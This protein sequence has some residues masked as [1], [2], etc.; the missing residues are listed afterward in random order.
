MFLSAALAV[1]SAR[2]TVVPLVDAVAF[3]STAAAESRPR[4]TVCERYEAMS[5]P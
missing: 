5:Q 1:C 3:R 2:L 4:V